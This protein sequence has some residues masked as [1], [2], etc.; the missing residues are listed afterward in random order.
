MLL[1][2]DGKTRVQTAQSKL[3]NDVL[4]VA[5]LK[6]A[7]APGAPIKGSKVPAGS[8]NP[9]SRTEPSARAAADSNRRGLQ[10]QIQSIDRQMLM[11][12]REIGRLTDEAASARARGRPSTYNDRTIAALNSQLGALEAQRSDLNYKIA[13]LPR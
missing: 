2:D 8:S 13:K 12:R 7:A 10:T 9:P 5:A 1:V 4:E 6:Q 11:I 3:T